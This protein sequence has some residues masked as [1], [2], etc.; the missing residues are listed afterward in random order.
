MKKALFMMMVLILIA[1]EPEEKVVYMYPDDEV[2]NVNDIE[3][4]DPESL[5]DSNGEYVDELQDDP[6][7]NSRFL[8]YYSL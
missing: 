4:N 6:V 1:C 3:S 8:M 7:D 2:N 5:D